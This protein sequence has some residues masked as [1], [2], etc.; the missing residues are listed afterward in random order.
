MIRVADCTVVVTASK[1]KKPARA[2]SS[3]CDV[4]EGLDRCQSIGLT[5]SAR[6]PFGPSPSVYSTFWPSRR[7]S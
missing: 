1:Q 5:F 6:G 2:G 4:S 3:F 7:S